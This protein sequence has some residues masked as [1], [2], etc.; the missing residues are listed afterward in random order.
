MKYLDRLRE[1]YEATDRD[2][3][4]YIG[5]GIALFLLLL[6]IFTTANQRIS[7]LE[8]KRKAREAQL[9]EMIELKQRF[10]AAKT[11]YQRFTGRLAAT[12]VDDS[13]GRI[14]ESIGIKGKSG[15]VTPLKGEQREGFVEDAAEVLMEG[16]TANEAVNLVYRLE[17]GEKPV[18][19]KKANFKTRFDDPSRLD[20]TLAIALLKPAQQDRK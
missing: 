5:V 12:A 2:A 16:L 10:L 3:R 18:L 11:S 4:L 17:K 13:P 14:V 6:V 1:L 7:G 20:V 9:V 19:V 8:K 15:R